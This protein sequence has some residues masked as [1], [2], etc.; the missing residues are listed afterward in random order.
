MAERPTARILS[1]ENDECWWGEH[2]GDGVYKSLN[3]ALSAAP[4][5]LPADYDMGPMRES[6]PG[7]P[8]PEENGKSFRICWGHL[9]KCGKTS[10]GLQVVSI[11][12]W[13]GE[14]EAK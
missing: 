2:V 1:I 10:R 4:L 7:Y 14:P 9:L 8:G 13:E 11:V 3:H 6:L 12:G 5:A